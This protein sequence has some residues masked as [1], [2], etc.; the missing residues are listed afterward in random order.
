[1]KEKK[2][3][4][5]NKLFISIAVAMS[6]VL[7]PGL[8]LSKEKDD[9]TITLSESNLL[10]LDQ[11][12]MPEKM[13][14]LIF[15]AKS[16]DN[17][18]SGLMGLG[19]KK[20]IYL[21]LNTPGGSIQTG[22]ELIEALKGMGRP[23]DTITLFAASMGFQVSQQL[24]ERYV[25]KN[26]VMMSHRAQG[27]IEGYFGGQSPSQMDNRYNL[28][29]RRINEL[30]EATVKRTKGKQTM[31]SYRKA[32]AD[33]LWMTGSEAVEKGYADKVVSV[34]C[35]KSLVGTNHH[36]MSVFGLSLEYETD[37]CPINTSPM[38]IK[39]SVDTN[40][41]LIY[42][43]Q[44]LEKNGSFDANCMAAA[45]ADDKRLCAVNPT[46]NPQK[47]QEIIEKFKEQFVIDKTRALPLTW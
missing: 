17:S 34:K 6:V 10:V 29:L 35:D 23:I 27:S 8:S 42:F 45:V 36:K 11:E 30:D 26:G 33:E 46:L 40:K 4:K 12:I 41:G 19:S 3:M 18:L 21:F 44:F 37:K 13:G 2:I 43:T 16:K 25:V 47:I 1:M 15:D 5:L 20:P 28:W 31:E 38:H 9:S 24:G 39:I 7:F 14:D 22:L 32:Y